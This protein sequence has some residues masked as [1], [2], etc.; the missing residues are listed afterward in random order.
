MYWEKCLKCNYSTIAEDTSKSRYFGGKIT[1]PESDTNDLK[2][3]RVTNDLVVRWQEGFND[4]EDKNCFKGHNWLELWNN[5]GKEKKKIIPT[6]VNFGPWLRSYN[7]VTVANDPR[8]C[9]RFVRAVTKHAPIGEYRQRFF[10]L[11]DHYCPGHENTPET[12]DHI[13]N[14][15]TWY[16]RRLDH[17]K[18]GIETITG[19]IL[20]L[21]D[22]PD[23][24][25]W[26]KM[27]VPRNRKRDWPS[28][29]KEVYEQR[30]RENEIRR[31][32]G[33]DIEKGPIFIHE[34]IGY[35][36]QIQRQAFERLVEE[37]MDD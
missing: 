14:E 25:G 33:I 21:C 9:G 13:L 5:R 23:A 7:G 12:R 19:F 37:N 6:H 28:Y 26:D 34:T 10:P 1:F 35:Y 8:L 36:Y 22:N 29:R 24:F 30:E 31:R 11:E 17:Y 3:K 32:K 20:F 4:E 27:E 2:R 18:G 16:V 15:C